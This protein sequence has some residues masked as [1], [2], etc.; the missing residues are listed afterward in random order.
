M[1]NNLSTNELYDLNDY[2]QLTN[3]I[4]EIVTDKKSR[5]EL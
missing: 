5:K 1:E 4:G 3:S 2:E